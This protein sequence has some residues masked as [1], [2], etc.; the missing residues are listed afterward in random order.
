MPEPAPGHRGSTPTGIR[1]RPPAGA[2]ATPREA[3]ELASIPRAAVAFGVMLVRDLGHAWQLVHQPDHGRLC[4]ELAELWADGPALRPE[5]LGALVLA[6]RRHDD[7]WAVWE[8][9]P[10]LDAEGRPQSFLAVSVP[11]LLSSYR[12]CA[13]IVSAES[14]GAGLFV[15]MHVSGLQRGRYGVMGGPVRALEDLDPQVRE[16]VVAEEERQSQ[17]LGS[18]GFSEEERWR[19]YRQLQFFDTVSLYCGLADPEKDSWT[20]GSD[21]T[22]EPVRGAGAGD[23]GRMVV[24]PGGA[25]GT[26]HCRPYPF[27]TRPVQVHLRRRVVGKRNW[28]DDESFRS[29]FED[30]AL[31]R[32]T[33][34]LTG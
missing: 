26:V 21:A 29:D 4:G 23:L 19:A 6:A 11:S 5:V 34:T 8:R 3:P 18:L 1:V 2:Q 30:A 25:P 24:G 15:S 32:V 33:L 31:E 13:D 14:P 9:E 22:A 16:F 20:L 28:P 10:R 12:A 17:L 27:V 7:G